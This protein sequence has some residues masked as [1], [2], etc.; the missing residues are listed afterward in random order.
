MKLINTENMNRYKLLAIELH[1]LEIYGKVLKDRGGIDESKLII[2]NSE[3]FLQIAN[4][5]NKAKMLYPPLYGNPEINELR[6]KYM[7]A[8]IRVVD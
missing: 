6:D 8:Q 1:Y 7:G 3:E 2:I 5:F 4:E